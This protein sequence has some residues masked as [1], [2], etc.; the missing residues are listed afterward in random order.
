MSDALRV[1]P[2]MGTV[3]SFDVRDAD[4]DEVEIDAAVGTAIGWLHEV[5]ERFSPFLP[6][7]EVSRLADGTLV[8]ANAH[9][10]VRAVLAM[11]DD[12][13]V[14]SM[15]AFDARA[16]NPD[17]RLDPSGLVKGWAVQLAADR[18]ITAGLRS[19]AINAGGDIVACG[20]PTAIEEW[21]VGIRHPDH[22]DRVAAVLAVADRA[23]ATSGAYERGDHILDP[24]TG[25]A[26]D[27]L[28]SVTVVGPSL[29][30][31]DAYA[32]AAFVMGVDGLGWVAGHR[33]YEAYAI[34]P[35][36]RVV[37]TEGMDRYLTS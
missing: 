6:D 9:P 27:G 17:H 23:V 20:R 31:A 34:T 14:D 8:E 22:A 33:G 36:D 2:V 1:E 18:L 12:L 37:W 10:D 3:V 19:F 16:W 7:S 21:R 30:W 4:L 32:T 24:R 11:C 15:G 29:A 25:Q 28:R 35:D 26:P 13:M 5:D